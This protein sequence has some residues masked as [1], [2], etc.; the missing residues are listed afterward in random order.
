MI[1]YQVYKLIHLSAIF[2]F[3]MGA[4]VLLLSQTK[5][6]F[7]R[8]WTGVTAFFILLGGMG[9]LARL[10]T[11]W[12]PWLTAKLIIWLVITGLGHMVAKRMPERGRAAFFVTYLLAITAAFVAIYKP[13]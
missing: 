10:G 12:Q 9:L 13:F 2:G 4:A 7:W 3:L 1:S 11:G 6:R 8:V 5:G